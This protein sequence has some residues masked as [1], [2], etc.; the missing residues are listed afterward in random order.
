MQLK[1]NC[2]LDTATIMDAGCWMFDVDVALRCVL[3]MM[4]MGMLR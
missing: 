3:R 4:E 1:R 2:S